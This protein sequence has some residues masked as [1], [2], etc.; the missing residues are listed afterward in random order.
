ME[1]PRWED[2]RYARMPDVKENRFTWFGNGLTVAQERGEKTTEYLDDCDV[3]PVIN[4]GP[5][6]KAQSENGTLKKPGDGVLDGAWVR[7]A[8]GVSTMPS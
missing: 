2:F 3:P 6:P 4:P 7:V 8:E 1:N 5:R